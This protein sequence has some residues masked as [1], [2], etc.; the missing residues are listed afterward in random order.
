LTIPAVRNLLLYET[1]LEINIVRDPGG[2]AV[3]TTLS[4][5]S[6]AT[7]V[8]L[9]EGFAYLIELSYDLRVPFGV[10]PPFSFSL[11]IKFGVAP[12]PGLGME[13]LIFVGLALMFAG[14]VFQARRAKA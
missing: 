1:F 10:D 14:V 6:A 2:A 9:P 13:A 5:G 11:P 8:T 7:T 12:V 3:T 4:P